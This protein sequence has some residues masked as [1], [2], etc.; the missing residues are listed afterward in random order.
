M[1][2]T[3]ELIFSVYVRRLCEKSM[4]NSRIVDRILR[5]FNFI[6]CIQLL[7]MNLIS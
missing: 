7:N 6:L 1:L 5:F 2:I 4:Q 3:I